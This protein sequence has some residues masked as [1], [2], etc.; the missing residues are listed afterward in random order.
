M[1]RPVGIPMSE[2]AKTKISGALKGRIPKNLLQIQGWNKGTKGVM[3]ANSGSFTSETAALTKLSDEGRERLRTFHMGRKHSQETLKKIGNAHR[4]KQLTDEWRRKI[5]KSH[6][7]RVERGEHNF[8]KGGV[9]KKNRTERKLLMATVEY[10][11][12]RTSVFRRDNYTCQFCGITGVYVEADHI[13]SY[14][15]YPDLRLDI[16]NGR[17]LCKPC[18]LDVTFDRKRG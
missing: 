10:R 9:S 1:S 15:D 6:N 4:G 11:I 16:S 7:A 13:K 2:E 12:W 17:T 5:S 14:A 18:H 3:K 8:W